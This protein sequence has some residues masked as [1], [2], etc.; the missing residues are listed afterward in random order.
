MQM[1]KELR[2]CLNILACVAALAHAR[3]FAAE[4]DSASVRSTVL[5]VKIYIYY[6]GNNTNVFTNNAANLTGATID[7]AFDVTAVPST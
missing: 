4:P 5:T 3:A 2:R 7:L 1:P 6:D